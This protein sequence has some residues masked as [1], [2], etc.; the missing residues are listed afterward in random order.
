MNWFNHRGTLINLDRI[1][2]I[3]C[4]Y[5]SRAPEGSRA[6]IRFHFSEREYIDET[7]N[8]TSEMRDY[9]NRLGSKLNSLRHH[10]LLGDTP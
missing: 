6:S 5:D 1:I 7:F 4:F 8:T 3:E 9:F 2:K 10:D